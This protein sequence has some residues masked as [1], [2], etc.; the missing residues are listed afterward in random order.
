MVV[1]A[2]RLEL[3]RPDAGQH[4]HE[5]GGDDGA[6]P[7]QQPGGVAHGEHQRG[8]EGERV[9][10][11]GR[12]F[13][14]VGRQHDVKGVNHPGQRHVHDARPMR[15]QARR[16]AQAMHREIEPALARH[17]VA[18]L[19]GSRRVVG[20]GEAAR[21]PNLHGAGPAQCQCDRHGDEEGDEGRV[22]AAQPAWGRSGIAPAERNGAHIDPH[23]AR[24]PDGAVTL[25]GAPRT[26][27][28]SRGRAAGRW[29]PGRCRRARRWRPNGAA[30]PSPAP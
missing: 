20:I 5:G 15:Q 13:G 2:S 23:R 10:D 26:R 3:E 24:D 30:R 1:D 18:D 4:D 14:E 27:P 11:P 29:P 12:P 21:P 25:G 17:P 7:R 28:R 22:E 16:R 8:L 9:A 6:L 19:D